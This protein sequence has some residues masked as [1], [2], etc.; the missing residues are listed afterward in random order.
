MQKRTVRNVMALGTVTLLSLGMLVSGCTSP[1]STTRK[2]QIRQTT[3]SLPVRPTLSANVLD[4]VLREASQKGM[5]VIHNATVVPSGAYGPGQ[6]MMPAG[7]EYD[8][9]ALDGVHFY[10]K[11]E[12]DTL[13]MAGTPEGIKYISGKGA[14]RYG[15]K[16]YCFGF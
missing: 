1:A 7:T 2:T 4:R 3:E 16:L 9:L 6:M 14:I 12:A 5:E 11:N 15:N 10:Y 13:T 8:G